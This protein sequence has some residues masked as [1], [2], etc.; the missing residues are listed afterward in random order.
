MISLLHSLLHHFKIEIYLIWY[1]HFTIY[2]PFKY[3]FT[4]EKCKCLIYI[5]IIIFIRITKNYSFRSK[6][7]FDWSHQWNGRF[8]HLLIS[9][10][11]IIFLCIF[12]LVFKYIYFA[13][14]IQIHTTRSGFCGFAMLILEYQTCEKAMK[15]NEIKRT[16]VKYRFWDCLIIQ[17]ILHLLSYEKGEL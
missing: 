8:F 11:D 10:Y 4:W 6:C 16:K 3:L 2:F 15:K 13:Y 17:E 12:Y 14:H 1:L 5:S 7:K 9:A